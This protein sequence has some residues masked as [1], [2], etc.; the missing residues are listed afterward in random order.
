MPSQ[1]L[2]APVNYI[3]YVA[4]NDSLTLASDSVT[5]ARAAGADA[6]DALYYASR[7]LSVSHRL[8][9]P[10][11]LDQ[12]ESGGIGLRVFVGNRFATVSSSDTSAGAL[13]ELA[14]R[15]VAMARLAPEDAFSKLAPRE[16]LAGSVP[17]LELYD[18]T[19]P[20]AR[21]LQRACAEAEESALAM[22]GITNSEGASAGYGHTEF[23]LVTSNGFAHAYRSSHY[24]VSVS[25]L[26]GSGTA[27]ERDYDYSSTRFTADLKS[28]AAIG[29]EA[30]SR[31]L[32]RLHPRKVSTQTVPVVFDPRVARRLLSSFAG[33]IN[34]SSIARGTS[35]LKGAMN[36]QVFSPSVTIIDE[37]HRKRGM[38][39]RPF[40]GEGLPT[41]RTELVKDGVLQ[42]WL[43]DM[44]SAGKLGLAP[45]GHA[46]RGL[47]SP[48]S[49]STSNC[50]IAAGTLSPQELMADIKDGF[51]VTELIGMGVNMVTGDFSQGASGFWIEGGKRA[52]PVSE[53]TIAGTLQEMF[54]NLQ[55]AND[56]CFDYATNA[57]TLRVGQMTIAGQ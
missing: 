26:A 21:T 35:F 6:A 45:T 34:G 22:E 41:R 15:A 42:T 14:T 9:K 29:R 46:S 30:A 39:S 7:S 20:D 38:G 32:A 57:P 4:M 51:Y 1:S 13:S 40:D 23:A 33:A 25:V 47:S 3:I 52:Y 27:M 37:P 36:T 17:D 49:P 12:S 50:Y 54:A 11:G 28:P 53:V 19:E 56:L 55:A 16:L 8:G 2:P 10:E 48:P 31:A 43:L 24:S 44:R 18:A 5:A